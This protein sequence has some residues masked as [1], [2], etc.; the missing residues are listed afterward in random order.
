[1]TDPCSNEHNLR[2]HKQGAVY[3]SEVEWR[4]SPT[5][6]SKADRDIKPKKTLFFVISLIPIRT[7][8]SL[9]VSPTIL[10]VYPYARRKPKVNNECSRFSKQN[11]RKKTLFT[12]K[13]TNEKKKKKKTLFTIK[14][15]QQ[16]KRTEHKP[17]PFSI[18][19]VRI[20]LLFF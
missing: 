9:A 19:I 4:D 11:K 17:V 3:R 7:I 16:K 12:I 20:F 10:F 8:F 14:I 2:Y 18:W 13:S 1:M 15:N 6:T 5:K